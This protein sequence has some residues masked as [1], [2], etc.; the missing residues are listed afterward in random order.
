MLP[1]TVTTS[2]L[3]QVIYNKSFT[4]SHLQQVIYNKSFTTS[5]LQQ[6]I[7]NK[8]FTTSH[9]QQVIYNK[10]FTTSDLQ[11][12][13]Y[14]KWFT[15][16]DL[17]QVIYNLQ[18]VIY[19]KWFTTSLPNATGIKKKLF[20]LYTYFYFVLT[21]LHYLENLFYFI[22]IPKNILIILN[23]N[24]DIFFESSIKKKRKNDVIFIL[25][26][27]I[28]QVR[29]GSVYSERSEAKGRAESRELGWKRRKWIKKKRYDDDDDDDD[30]VFC[31][32][33]SPLQIWRKVSFFEENFVFSRKVT[34]TLS[35]FPFFLWA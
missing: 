16:S 12:V 22:I 24:M 19:N 9:L 8:S 34:K 10:W 25:F 23:E 35:F 32:P 33:P 2:D 4:T 18:Q 26:T 11:Q 1:R 7:Y 6:V 28:S 30:H 5:H 15:T 29:P 20:L 31:T 3:Q 21:Q 14:N 13:I 17:Q 27:F